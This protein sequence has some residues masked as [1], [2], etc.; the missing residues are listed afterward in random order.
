MYEVPDS[1]IPLSE[2][3]KAAIA[4]LSPVE[5]LAV[6]DALMSNTLERWRKMAMVVATTMNESDS[7][8]ELP[9]VFFANRVRALVAS[10]RLEYQGDLGHMRYC[11]VRR[12]DIA[13]ARP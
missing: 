4:A 3:K 5:V 8:P 13:R 2:S 1:E 12:P 6:D 9:D 10:G 7:W 11:E